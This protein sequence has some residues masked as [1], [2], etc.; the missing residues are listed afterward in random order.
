M[1]KPSL[2]QNSSPK[3]NKPNAKNAN[4]QPDGTNKSRFPAPP[5]SR[6]TNS[7]SNDIDLDKLQ[8][9]LEADDLVRLTRSPLRLPS[10]ME[11]VRAEWIIGTL[12]LGI[13]FFVTVGDLAVNK[14]SIAPIRLI[15]DGALLLLINF[16]FMVA[17]TRQLSRRVRFIILGLQ[18]LFW[19]LTVQI[20]P[21]DLTIF[22][23]FIPFF[24]LVAEVQ[25]MFRTR[26]A[27]ITTIGCWLV[28]YAALSTTDEPIIHSGFLLILLMFTVPLVFVSVVSRFVI[29]EAKQRRNLIVALNRLRRSEERY[30]QVTLRANDAI[31]ILDA[32]GRFSF[33]NPKICELSGWE[34]QELLGQHFTSILSPES[35]YAVMESY[36]RSE[37]EQRASDG[38]IIASILCK[39]DSTRIVEINSA[40][41]Y[42]DNRLSGRVCVA[43]DIT[44]RQKMREE[45]DRHNRELTALNAVIST[46]G[47]S[48]EL[49]KVLN[50]VVNTLVEVLGADIAGVTLK[51]EGTRVLKVAAYKGASDMVVRTVTSGENSG[52]TSL[53][54]KVVETGE[55]LLIRDMSR[56]ARVPPNTAKEIGLQSFA[57]APIRSRDA[58]IGVLS[59]ISHRRNAFSENDLELLTSIGSQLSVA[60]E[61]ARLY[62][63]S[64]NQVRELMCLAE[65]ARAINLSQSLGQTLCSVAESVCTTLEYAAG[66]VYLLDKEF[67]LITAYGTFGL[68]DQYVSG[69]S[70]SINIWANLP[71][72]EQP[73]VYKALF[74]PEPSVFSVKKIQKI[75]GHPEFVETMQKMECKTLICMPLVQQG[76][77]IGFISC[78]SREELPP[79]ESELRLL[80]TI[81]NQTIVA[82]QNAGLYRE[83]QRRAD[84]LR[85]VSEIGQKIGSILSVDE[86]LP[87]MTSLLHQTF[88]YFNVSV[89]LIDPNNNREL[90]LRSRTGWNAESDEKICIS[91]DGQGI[92]PWVTKAGVAEIV[93]DVTKDTRYV[94]WP[95]LELVR[96]ELA[97]P[98]RVGGVVV[99][100]L[101]VESTFV[102]AFD[103]IDLAT[104]NVMADHVGIAIS[105][106]RLFQAQ[107]RR[108]EQLRA[109]NEITQKIGTLM[110]LEELLPYSTRLLCDSFNY[111][112][113]AIFLLDE[114]SNQLVLTAISDVH[115][116][117]I[118]NDWG[119]ECISLDSN[120]VLTQAAHSGQASLIN[121]V[122]SSGQANL[123]RMDELV[124]AELCVPIRSGGRVV[125]V[126]DIVSHSANVFDETDLAASQVLADQV[127]IGIENARLYT[128]LN[129]FVE[130]LKATNSDLEEATRHKSEFLA[131]MSHEL[132][133]PLNAIIGFSEVL[134]DQVFGELNPRQSRYVTNILTSGRHLLTLVNDVL[135]LSKVEA[136]K[137]ELHPENFSINEAITDVEAIVIGM[138]NKKRLNLSHQLGSDLPFIMA[139]KSKFKQILYN[140]LSNAVKFTPEGGA[141]T[142]CSSLKRGLTEAES[143]FE[144]CVRDTG[145]G[146]RPEDQE[147][148]FEEFRQV[149]SSYSRQFQGT[150]LGLALSRRL[151][152]LHGGQL[153]VDSEPGKG[154][155]F[156]FSLPLVPVKIAANEQ[157]EAALISAS[158]DITL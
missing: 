118:N 33:V 72:A 83:Q 143:F 157:E 136:G 115:D 133:T 152:Q 58:V 38:N 117:H 66:A 23:T 134:Q 20:M 126:L 56:D 127:G 84:Q 41:I 18:L 12:I 112:H 142:V 82:V 73:N 150:G 105:N 147:R 123:S 121:N 108:A 48:L 57:A 74:S 32:T 106:A 139:D 111:D 60:I 156:T 4:N 101:D 124:A 122:F 36:R 17:R 22:F 35:R 14:F 79:P 102:N 85:A 109:V 153:W 9:E 27:T 15:A 91:L 40:L 55:P 132:R 93:P 30:R 26:I 96:S 71:E 99:G 34:M 114:P 110:T 5:P 130:Q 135:D 119:G 19:F 113:A 47:S 6:S 78:Y 95:G 39:D 24:P 68:A 98:I 107:K 146:I 104:M 29:R 61:N 52:A 70:Q 125:G 1:P 141:V 43:R 54:A 129:R 120:N 25:F 77:P 86:L 37:Q 28:L 154:S 89:F 87:F 11:G 2:N 138:A 116:D 50:D 13:F 65:I 80:T 51:E 137:M 69:L 64:L 42:E 92:V 90:E 44:E 46:A 45:M 7:K 31:Y 21:R 3:T 16:L 155:L 103:E 10:S 81:A 100:V 88:D 158:Q 59:L 128:Q 144:V 53:A 140:L 149:D 145:I 97:V 75:M 76:R 94:A 131:N 63:T 67:K 49:D 62:G 151:V 8:T 148:I